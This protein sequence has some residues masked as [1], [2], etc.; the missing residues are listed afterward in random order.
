[1]PK[2]QKLWKVIAQDSAFIDAKERVEI[3][4]IFADGWSI[5]QMV[6]LDSADAVL[7][8]MEREP[9]ATSGAGPRPF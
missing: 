7:L 9:K 3:E 5:K 6:A 8:L 4:D 2:E 1:M